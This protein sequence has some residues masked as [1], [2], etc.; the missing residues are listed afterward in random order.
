MCLLCQRIPTLS[1]FVSLC[2]DSKPGKTGE[3]NEDPS[4]NGKDPPDI[5]D[6]EIVNDIDEYFEAGKEP[7][8]NNDVCTC[9]YYVCMY[10]RIIYIHMYMCVYSHMQLVFMYVCM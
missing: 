5:D 4:Q 10:C 3:E 6:E 8:Q 2:K 9:M 7:K 1:V